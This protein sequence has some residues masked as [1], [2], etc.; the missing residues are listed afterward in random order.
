MVRPGAGRYIKGSP[1]LGRLLEHDWRSAKGRQSWAAY[2][3]MTWMRSFKGQP[4][5]SLALLPPGWLGPALAT[6]LSGAGPLIGT[7]CARIS[8]FEVA[9]LWWFSGW[10][11]SAPVLSCASLNGCRAAYKGHNDQIVDQCCLCLSRCN[12][13]AGHAARTASSARRHDHASPY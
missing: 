6:S 4:P 9:S 5:K 7:D 1:V 11:G 10:L 2:W 8:L 13:G 3:N 12:I